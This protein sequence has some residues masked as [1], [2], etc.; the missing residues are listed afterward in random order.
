MSCYAGYQFESGI[1]S[2][3]QPNGVVSH[4]V[5]NLCINSMRK[6]VKQKTSL[7]QL[8]VLYFLRNKH[9]NILV[10]SSDKKRNCI[11]AH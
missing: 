3:T 5:A 8:L 2:V 1:I 4:L 6:L 7:A 10:S 11:Q 9:F